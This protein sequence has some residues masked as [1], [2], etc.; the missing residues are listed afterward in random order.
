[1]RRSTRR[2]IVRWLVALAIV[3]VMV[4]VAWH[5]MP[6]SRPPRPKPPAAAAAKGHA[7]PQSSPAGPAGAAA[8]AKS[9]AGGA[10]GNVTTAPASG[11]E[12]Q[13]AAT[14]AMLAG[15]GRWTAT[16]ADQAVRA[17]ERFIAAGKLAEGRAELS[18]AVLSGKLPADRAEMLRGKL[19]DLADKM[20]FSRRIYDGDPYVG[21]Y[22]FRQGDLLAKVERKLRLHVPP[23]LLLRINGLKDARRI[24]AGQTF[25]V[26]YGPFHAIVSK[27]DFTMDIFLHRAGNDPAYI[28]RLMV[29]VGRDGSTPVGLWRVKLGSKHEQATWYPPPSSPQRRSI[30]WGRQGYP[31]GKRGYWIGLEGI[32]PKTRG[33]MGY[34]IH[35]TNDPSSIGRAASLGCIRLADADIALVFSLLYENWSTVRVLP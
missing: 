6:E 18:K 17:G 10:A 5:F 35:G 15:L 23:P 34:G 25:K 7:G 3:A 13:S 24:R 14:E 20:L 8:G 19:S 28:R 2:A 29:G 33:H 1:M 27:S 30:Q 32:G 11:P 21:Q 12:G 31:L 4:V 9:T 22:V 26:I 16:Q